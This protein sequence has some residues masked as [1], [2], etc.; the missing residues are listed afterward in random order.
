MTAE[1]PA[2]PVALTDF[3]HAHD[4]LRSAE[5]CSSCLNDAEAHE[6][7]SQV[8]AASAHIR[9]RRLGIW[10]RSTLLFSCRV[11]LTAIGIVVSFILMHPEPRPTEAIVAPQHAPIQRVGENLREQSDP[12][13]DE[14]PRQFVYVKGIQTRSAKAL[15][16]V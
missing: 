11:F 16:N 13:V 15:N 7:L 6:R 10:V 9:R 4:R 3:I 8:R 14:V 12:A 2:S 1:A 5:L